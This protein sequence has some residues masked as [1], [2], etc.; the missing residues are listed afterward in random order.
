[1]TQSRFNAFLLSLAGVRHRG[2]AILAAVGLALLVTG[3]GGGGGD[4]TMSKAEFEQRVQKDG[5]QIRK[6]FTP[7]N[8]P[9]KSLNQLADELKTGED[10]L[11]KVADDLDKANPPKDVAEDTTKLATGLR[12]L[13]NELELMRT[14]A[15]KGDPALV[16]KALGSLRGSHALVD[17]QAATTDMKKK[18]YSLGT[19][20]Q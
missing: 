14:A 3:C 10:E 11:H 2:A 19:L 7:L 17:A 4:G 6:A 1:M 13:A 20:G 16:Q 18:G 12:K 15:E 8:T 5:D 9:P